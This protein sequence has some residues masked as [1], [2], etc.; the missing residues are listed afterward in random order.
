[1]NTFGHRFVSVTFSLVGFLLL[2]T[3][4]PDVAPFFIV[5]GFLSMILI[6]ILEE[7]KK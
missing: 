2:F 1:M 4:K 3:N 6:D 7:L 5:S